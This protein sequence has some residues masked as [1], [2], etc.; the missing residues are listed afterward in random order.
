MVVIARGFR[1]AED[2]PRPML[3][4]LDEWARRTLT[5]PEVWGSMLERCGQWADYSARNQ[6]LLASYGVATAVAGSVTWERLASVEPGRTCAVR[7]GEHGLPV[8][9]PVVEPGEAVS[10]R[11]RTPA[12]SVSNVAGLRWEMVFALEQLARRPAAGVLTMPVVSVLSERDWAN[13]VRV[14]SGR[15]LGRTPRR[16][17]D[18]AVQLA[19]LAARVG[20]GS[21]RLRLTGELA[22]QAGWLAA[23]MAGVE[24]TPM[25]PYAPTGLSGRERWRTLVDVR[26][27]TGELARVL[28]FALGVDLR[29]PVVPRHDLADDRTVTPGRR[30]CLAPADVRGLPLGVWIEAGPYTK[31]EWLARGV[32]GGS[33]VGAFC[34]VNDRSYLAVY[35]TRTGAMWRLETVGG[36]AHRG[37]VADGEADSLTAAKDAAHATLLARFPDAAHAMTAESS[38]AVR[39]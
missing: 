8:R 3:R 29:A 17:D 31:G 6:V 11:V 37:V 25:P 35:E 30:N 39:P 2:D 4:H 18:P 15:M 33:G 14:A 7:A 38:T 36:G 22:V 10:D 23:S 5:S 27:A 19:S 28:S 13:T 24:A 34:R 9:A 20:L 12:R 16:V 21:G 26:H 1:F 32:A